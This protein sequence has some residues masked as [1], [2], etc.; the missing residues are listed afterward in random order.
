MAHDHHYPR[1]WDPT[2]MQSV[3]PFIQ[4]KHSQHKVNKE[5][6]L[7]RKNIYADE[8]GVTISH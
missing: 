3:H 7:K 2:G 1:S 5:K 4:T 6:F 8:T